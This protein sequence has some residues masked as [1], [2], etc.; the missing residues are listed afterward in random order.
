MAAQWQAAYKSSMSEI[1][2]GAFLNQYC[3]LIK[4]GKIAGVGDSCCMKT[5]DWH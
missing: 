2:A 4:E 1:C 5:F 3:N